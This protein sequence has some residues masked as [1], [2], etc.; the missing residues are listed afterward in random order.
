MK[1]NDSE[2]DLFHKDAFELMESLKDESVD[3]V[4]TD[5]PYS[6]GYSDTHSEVSDWD[7]MTDNEYRDFMGRLFFEIGRVL[8]PGGQ[9]WV[10]YGIT[11]IESVIESFYGSFMDGRGLQINWE[12]ALVYA[13]NKGRGS[14]KK[15]KSLREE[16]LHVSKGKPKTWNSVE[17]YRRVLCPYVKDGK[18]R[19]WALDI[20]TG[21]PTRFVGAGNVM[22]FSAPNY[23]SKY[24]KLIHSAQ[25]PILLNSALVMMSSKVG[26]VVLDPFMGSG[27]CGVASVL[28][29]RNFIG[30]EREKEVF[31]KAANWIE[32]ADYEAMSVDYVKKHLSSSEKGFKFGHDKRAILPK[33]V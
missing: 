15:L 18:P 32:N 31:D 3:V 29:G 13:R 22:F 26:D 9:A 6:I 1:I 33:K 8:R 17:Y 10:F 7:H 23:T 30:V 5:P 16:V 24:E 19:G 4:V 12:N 28:C 20:S 11:K 14:T 27:S 2:V 25:K 21:E